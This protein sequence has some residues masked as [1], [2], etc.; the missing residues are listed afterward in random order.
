MAQD[1]VG[2]DWT[3]STD[4]PQGRVWLFDR[5]GDLGSYMFE[6]GQADSEV[7][8]NG[9]EPGFWSDMAFTPDGVFWAKLRAGQDEGTLAS[10]DG[11]DWT[12]HPLPDGSPIGAIETTP[13]RAIL[14]TQSVEEGPGP[15]VAR[16]DSD[17]WTM[18]P[19]SD[20]PALAGS[21]HG[22]AG[23]LAAAPDGTVWL[24]NGFLHGGGPSLSVPGLAAQGLL[25]FDGVR[26]QS[27]EPMP[28]APAMRAGPL[29]V[30]PDG[31]LWVYM[32]GEM[33]QNRHLARWTDGAWSVFSK[34]AD[35]VPE[36]VQF[37]NWESRF[38]VDG[39]GT[40]WM[41]N[42]GR[43]ESPARRDRGSLPGR[44]LV[45]R[46]RLEAVSRRRL[47]S[48]RHGPRGRTSRVRLGDFRWP[49]RHQPRGR[50]GHRVV[51]SRPCSRPV[52]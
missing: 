14:V 36:L 5:G 52:P 7:W 51:G 16:L 15:L 28:D 26:W 24:S 18:L 50:G 31:T 41:P 4:R 47:P 19:T 33:G 29:A 27:V 9:V 45:R 30:G 11:A 32:L 40:L 25:H 39:D 38:E 8:S 44:A 46:E 48:A 34:K 17:G 42:S 43:A 35:N 6:L 23:Y 1:T 49:L 22:A 37:Q 13:D 10:F 2:E 12:E 20:D 21:Y 3:A